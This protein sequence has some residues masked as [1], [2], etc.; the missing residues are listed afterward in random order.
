MIAEVL[1]S[2]LGIFTG[3]KEGRDSA[4]SEEA[5]RNTPL[6]YWCTL[7]EDFHYSPQEFYQLVLERLQRRQVPD[8]LSDNILMRESHALS[9]RRLYLQMRR[10]RSP[11]QR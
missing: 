8:L 6:S 5:K 4:S 9:R 11:S 10:Q 3:S 2:I 1:R 7:F